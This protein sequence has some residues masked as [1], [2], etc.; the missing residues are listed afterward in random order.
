MGEWTS[1]PTQR[2]LLFI[3]ILTYH[4]SGLAVLDGMLT[5][6]EFWSV[7]AALSKW[8][9]RGGVVEMLCRDSLLLPWLQMKERHLRGYTETPIKEVWPETTAY[10]EDSLQRLRPIKDQ[11]IT[12]ATLPGI[13]AKRATALWD[14]L[15]TSHA[16]QTLAQAIVWLLEGYA[17]EVH[18][19]GD[20]TVRR[21]KEWFGMKPNEHLTVYTEEETEP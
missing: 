11:R 12:L 8:H 17:T 20:V 6:K 21:N 5:D 19:I 2:V 15:K 10:E 14:A 9:D 7:Q 1:R 16:D 13:G 3:G 18:G 4:D